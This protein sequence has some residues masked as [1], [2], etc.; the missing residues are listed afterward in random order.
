MKRILFT[1]VLIFV[2]VNASAA[3]LTETDYTSPLVI[4]SE[5]ANVKYSE[6]GRVEL[7]TLQVGE[8]IDFGENPELDGMIHSVMLV[9]AGFPHDYIT[10]FE[11]D[12]LFSHKHV[13]DF[14]VTAGEMTGEFGKTIDL[15]APGD[16]YLQVDAMPQGGHF[17]AIYDITVPE[18]PAPPETKDAVPTNAGIVI[19]GVEHNFD[20]YN[21]EGNNYFKL[22]DIAYAINGSSKQF[23]VTWN[24]AARAIDIIPGQGYTAVGGEMSLG[25]T[26]S[27]EAL[28]SDAQI[29]M[30]G[31]EIRLTAYNIKGNNY[32]KLR[33]LGE[34]IDFAV[35]WDGAARVITVTTS[36]GYTPE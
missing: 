12:K 15:G 5:D 7:I 29:L 13:P 6:D 36:M 34:V 27:Y 24:D 25:D 14:T 19:D 18:P 21:V 17:I 16:Y 1:L 33:D 30:N 32:F 8:S 4:L 2:A 35:E 23:E 22:R 26:M 11:S 20:A 3:A 28:L 10:I 31:E 9:S